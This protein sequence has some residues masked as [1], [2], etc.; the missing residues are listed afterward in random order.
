MSCC[1]YPELSLVAQ[2]EPHP[3]TPALLSGKWESTCNS[4]RGSDSAQ[5]EVGGP[6]RQ[7][8]L[9][10]ACTPSTYPHQTVL[11]SCLSSQEC[12]LWS[13]AVLGPSRGLKTPLSTGSP[14]SAARGPSL[15]FSRRQDY[16]HKE[17]ML[18]VMSLFTQLP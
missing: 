18:S 12:L 4:Q 3:L 2:G 16:T 14:V 9:C 6:V 11:R 15:A 17:N 7:R 13:A 1:F 5:W 10:P 8:A